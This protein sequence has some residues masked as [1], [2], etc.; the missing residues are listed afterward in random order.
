MPKNSAKTYSGKTALY[1]SLIANMKAV[2]EE[3][4]EPTEKQKMT[5]LELIGPVAGR[6]SA[7]C[8]DDSSESDSDSGSGSGSESDSD[9]GSG[10]ESEDSSS[11]SDSC[12]GD[13]CKRSYREGPRAK[14]R[15]LYKKNGGTESKWR[16]KSEKFKDN[17]YEK[18]NGKNVEVPA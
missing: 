18:Y 3:C 17:Y 9:S 7:P 15:R 12:D 4:E 14:G 11:E 1:K 6:I 16:E 5:I 8:C 10:S 13:Y 2:L